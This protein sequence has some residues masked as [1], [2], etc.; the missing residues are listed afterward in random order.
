MF[1]DTKAFSGL[2]A[3]PRTHLITPRPAPEGP[4]RGGTGT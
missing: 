2:N 1:A 3:G 4:S